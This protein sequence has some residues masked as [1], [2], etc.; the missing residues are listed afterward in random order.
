[1]NKV[2]L[3]TLIM[4]LGSCSSFTGF[5]GLS[6]KNN[7]ISGTY[8]GVTKYKMP[9]IGPNRAAT[10][11]YLNEIEGEPGSYYA[12]LLEYVN[13][14]KMSPRYIAANK[15]PIASKVVGYLKDIT[16]K[17]AAFKVVPAAEEGTYEMQ[18]LKVVGGKIQAVVSEK[19]P[20]LVLSKDENIKFALEG[21]KIIPAKKGKLKHIYFPAD[22]KKDNGVQHS[23]AKFVYEK[24]GL[25]STW[26]KSFLPGPYLA[27]YGSKKDV[28][29]DLVK[30]D[31]SL[32]AN[33]K[34]NPKKKKTAKWYRQKQFTN[35]K[36]AYLNGEFS[37]EEPVDGMFTFIATKSEKKTTSE[38]SNRIGLFIDIFD[39][40]KALNQDVV[41][42]VMIN[43]EDPKDFL[44]YYE[45]PDNGEGD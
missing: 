11:I 17:V 26:R 5:R 43:T 22:D 16:S 41:E 39:A 18:S 15:L 4:L 34:L 21:A 38:V 24:V 29:L 33:F 42:L 35:K 28:V 27:S 45:H 30:S 2:I 37:V 3:L 19:Y 8:L 9:H 36:S 40:T 6:S 31:D 20:L 23:L 32:V 7:D 13:L 25:D 10:R 44:M 1:M 14:L 12:V